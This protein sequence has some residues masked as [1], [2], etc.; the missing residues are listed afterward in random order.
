ML[1]LANI[2]NASCGHKINYNYD[3]DNDKS[4]NIEWL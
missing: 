2:F 4:C 3:S 1:Y